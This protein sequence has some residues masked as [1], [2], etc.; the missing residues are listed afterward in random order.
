[1]FSHWEEVRVGLDGWHRCPHRRNALQTGLGLSSHVLQELDCSQPCTSSFH[2]YFSLEKTWDGWIQIFP[3][4][5]WKVCSWLYREEATICSLQRF[6]F[7][8]FAPYLLARTLELSVKECIFFLS[9][10]SIKIAHLCEGC[11]AC[12]TVLGW[13][14]CFDTNISWPSL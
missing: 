6:N 5:Y 13:R 10:H 3:G 8:Y 9:P 2:K 1:M 4:R 14:E 11:V 7:I 12:R